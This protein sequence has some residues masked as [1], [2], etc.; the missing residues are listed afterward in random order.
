[1][2]FSKQFADFRIVSALTTQLSWA[3]VVEVLPL[4]ATEVRLFYLSEATNCQIA[5]C[6]PQAV[7]LSVNR[8]PRSPP[9][10]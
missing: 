7:H 10:R 3:Y 2:Q 6:R 1:M 5:T 8:A 9:Y 4:K